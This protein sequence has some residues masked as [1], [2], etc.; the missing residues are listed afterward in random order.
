MNKI[1][2]RESGFWTTLF[3]CEKGDTMDRTRCRRKAIR[4]TDYEI[5]RIERDAEERGMNFSQYIRFLTKNKPG[6]H[7]E[8]IKV[9]KEL[10]NEIN[11]I[12]NN[13]NQIARSCNWGFYT[14]ED[15]KIL[16]AY[17]REINYKVN[18]LIELYSK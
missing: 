11:H 17:M 16:F 4:F 12:G 10:I 6:E 9:F 15:K 14:E 8:V 18:E 7:I 3:A 13:V 1:Q 2:L 5:K